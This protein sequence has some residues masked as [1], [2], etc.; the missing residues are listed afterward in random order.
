MKLNIIALIIVPTLLA[1]G[2]TH[3]TTVWNTGMDKE[4][5][6]VLQADTKIL[7]STY[8]WQIMENN[9]PVVTDKEITFESDIPS[10]LI[11]GEISEFNQEMN[12]L[13][14]G[15]KNIR[16]L[17]YELNDGWL[18]TRW[19]GWVNV[20]QYPMVYSSTGD[21]FFI[22][23]VNDKEYYLYRYS[24]GIWEYRNLSEEWY[25]RNIFHLDP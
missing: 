6:A 20:T 25:D 23:E 2:T 18:E 13:Y 16:Q 22:H 1:Q 24:D 14:V 12:A 17:D 10:I 5:V 3:Y 7:V 11:G 4:V 15:G 19:L 8:Q 21:W 9:W